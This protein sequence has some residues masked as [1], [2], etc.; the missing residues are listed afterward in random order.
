MCLGCY[1]LSGSAEV[2]E[3]FRK[4]GVVSSSCE[5]YSQLIIIEGGVKRALS[6]PVDAF[7]APL[8]RQRVSEPSED[9]AT[10]SAASNTFLRTTIDRSY[11]A[12]PVPQ[13]PPLWWRRFPPPPHRCFACHSGVLFPSTMKRNL[14]AREQR[15]KLGAGNRQKHAVLPT[16]TG[17]SQDSSADTEDPPLKQDASRHGDGDKLDT[18][19]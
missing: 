6:E 12:L 10:S 3:A 1:E 8:R 9:N 15:I 2:R 7:G 16:G 5:V 19:G 17:G 13:P 11:R 18:P 14:E 4:A